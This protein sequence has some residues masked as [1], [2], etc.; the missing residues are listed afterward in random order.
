VT[1]PL[2]EPADLDALRDAWPG[3]LKRLDPATRVALDPSQPAILNEGSLIVH[4]RG[5]MLAVASRYGEAL[6]RAVAEECGVR[7]EPSF[8]AA[9]EAPRPRATNGAAEVDAAPESEPPV[10]SEA[11][12]ARLLSEF[13]AHEEQD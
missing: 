3:V 7:V 1:A 13:D 5:S 9:D 12:A 6:A 2:A 10:G 8:S 11:L 4:V